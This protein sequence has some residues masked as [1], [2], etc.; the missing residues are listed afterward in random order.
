MDPAGIATPDAGLNHSSLV[1]FGEDQSG[2]LYLVSFLNGTLSKLT[3][4][5]DPLPVKLAFFKLTER[6]GS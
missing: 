6:E 4:P 5:D 1:S 2:E 3:N